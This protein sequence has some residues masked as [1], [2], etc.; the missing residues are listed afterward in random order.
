MPSIIYTQQLAQVGRS[1]R[2]SGVLAGDALFKQKFDNA[3]AIVL[4]GSVAQIAS[5][6]TIDLPNLDDNVQADIVKDNVL[7]VSA[8][9]FSA[10]LEELKFF[11]VADK[12]AE[13]FESSVIPMSRGTGGDAIYQYMR[14]ATQRFTE[15]ERRGIYARAFGFAQGSVDEQLPNREFADLW[16]R[17]LSAVSVFTREENATIRQSLTAQQVFK[18]ARD[19]AVNISLHGY[20]IAHFA[21]VELQDTIKKVIKMLGYPEVLSAYGVNDVWQLIERVS[22]LYLGGSVNSVRQRTLAQAGAEVIQWLAKKQ[23]ALVSPTASGIN[24]LHEHQLIN[25]VERW[26]AVTGTDDQATDK[27]SEPVSIPQQPTIPNMSLQQMALPQSL[28]SIVPQVTNS[29][30]GAFAQMPNIAPAKA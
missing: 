13:Q 2:E 19:L 28:Q 18:N 25:N 7:A 9:Y 10:Q 23:N 8:L 29:L 1:L 30:Q 27:F 12:V 17:F 21:A 20:G 24:F 3:W 16:I 5:Q 14:A 22:G 15:A 6:I 26:L 4:N 11:A